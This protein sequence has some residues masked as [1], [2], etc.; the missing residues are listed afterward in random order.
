MTPAQSL[1]PLP[2]LFFTDDGRRCLTSRCL[3]LTEFFGASG[4]CCMLFPL[5]GLIFL[6]PF[7]WL[8][9]SI[10]LLSSLLAAPSVTPSL[11]PTCFL[12]PHKA[13][14]SPKPWALPV[15]RHHLIICFM[16]DFA[17]GPQLR[18]SRNIRA[19]VSSSQLQPW[20]QR[21]TLCLGGGVFSQY[22]PNA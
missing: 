9:P 8:A 2:Q 6:K 7:A 14:A 16:L 1:A 4:P 15:L 19:H 22:L 10:P 18:N 5:P 3:R 13:L 12:I 17:I 21:L 20:L 11:H